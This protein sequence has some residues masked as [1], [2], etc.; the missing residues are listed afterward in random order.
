MY[1]LSDIYRDM[2]RRA[3]ELGFGSVVEH[4]GGRALRV[5]T[6][7][8]GTESPLLALEMVQRSELSFTINWIGEGS[9]LTLADLRED[10]GRCFDFKHL[11][12]A[13]IVPFKQAYIER[14]FH[15]RHLFRDVA[16]LK[17]RIA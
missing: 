15:P 1:Q 8:S 9:L 14:N 13:E 17:D 4:L 12:S 2:T 10:F 3:M 6:V 5:V 7:C 11:F 16:E